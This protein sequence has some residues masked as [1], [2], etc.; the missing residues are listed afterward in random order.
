MI[1]FVPLCSLHRLQCGVECRVERH[2]IFQILFMTTCQIHIIY[3]IIYLYMATLWECT[4][5][6][7]ILQAWASSIRP[8]WQ[9]QGPRPLLWHQLLLFLSVKESQTGAGQ[10]SQRRYRGEPS[11]R[12][13]CERQRPAAPTRTHGQTKS[14][15]RILALSCCLAVSSHCVADLTMV[16]PILTVQ[17]L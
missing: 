10:A 1:C 5:T 15:A 11:D 8:Y 7:Q 6:V 12:P 4:I 2:I 9:G 14:Y 16:T 3:V 17:R 13:G